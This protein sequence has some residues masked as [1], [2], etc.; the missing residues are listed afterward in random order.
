MF[1]WPGIHSSRVARDFFVRRRK[2]LPR[3]VAFQ[4]LAVDPGQKQMPLAFHQSKKSL[5][6]FHVYYNI[7]PI[8]SMVLVYML[9]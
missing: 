3:D 4:A 2:K 1:S 7:Y 5:K 9:T 8:G 6:A